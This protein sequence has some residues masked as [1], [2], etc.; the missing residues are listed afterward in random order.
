MSPLAPKLTSFCA[1]HEW[2]QMNL[3]LGIMCPNTV[4]KD[5]VRAAVSSYESKTPVEL[6]ILRSMNGVYLNK[7]STLPSKVLSLW[8]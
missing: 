6:W 5:T 4:Q 3:N 7:C 1:L 2:T 8:R